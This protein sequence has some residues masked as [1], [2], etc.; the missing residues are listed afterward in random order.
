[1]LLIQVQASLLAA[2][3]APAGNGRSSPQAPD[4]QP[5]PAA[6]TAE[7]SEL[8]PQDIG[9][10]AAGGVVPHPEVAGAGADGVAQAEA[11][12]AL[13]IVA[14]VV[15]R[16]NVTGA[17]QQAAVGI[18]AGSAGGVGGERAGGGDVDAEEVLVAAVVDLARDAVS[19]VRRDLS[20]PLVCANGEDRPLSGYKDAEFVKMAML[21]IKLGKKLIMVVEKFEELRQIVALSKQLGV[22]PQ[23]GIR[24]RL[25][26]KGGANGP[27]A[28]ART[29][30][31]AWF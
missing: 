8:D 29:P 30:S 7:G 31:S 24:T 25:L 13:S 6:P 12:V 27:R 17:V 10:G 15:F 23:L 16:K 3:E 9:A 2:G 19:N 14:V 28:P 4:E 21:G 1:M 26:T 20:F 11:Q 18:G 5:P 22:E